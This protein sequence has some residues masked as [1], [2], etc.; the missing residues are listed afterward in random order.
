M[1]LSFMQFTHLMFMFTTQFPLFVW[2]NLSLLF[3]MWAWS[4]NGIKTHLSIVIN[5]SL[6]YSHVWTSLI[7]QDVQCKR[8]YLPPCSPHTSSTFAIPT[9]HST[10]Y[11]LFVMFSI[12]HRF[13]LNYLSNKRYHRIGKSPFFQLS[14][15][16]TL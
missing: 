1:L 9:R 3:V 14:S 12:M 7:E 5:H 16:F 4:N 10:K 15:N 13:A 8:L 11:I 2:N 6:N